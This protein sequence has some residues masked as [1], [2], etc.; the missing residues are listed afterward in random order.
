MRTAQLLKQAIEDNQPKADFRSHIGASA[1]GDE[2]TLKLWLNYRFAA[3]PKF[4]ANTLLKFADGHASE[5]ITAK[6]LNETRGVT[7]VTENNGKQFTFSALGGHFGGSV[8]GI[9]CGV[10]Q[11]PFSKMIWEHKCVDQKE[12]NKIQRAIDK[13]GEDRALEK[14]NYKYYA[15]AQTYM[16]LSGIKNHFLTVATS[17]SRD[18]LDVVTRYNRAVALSLQHRANEIIL[19]DEGYD[20]IR[21]RADKYPCTYCSNSPICHGWQLPEVTCRS[22]I[23]G[24]PAKDSGWGCYL[25]GGQRNASEQMEACEQHLYLPAIV[26]KTLKQVDT[27]ERYVTYEHKLT[28][29]LIK[30]EVID[31][32][33]NSRNLHKQSLPEGE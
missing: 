31:G 4:D 30:N 15:Q 7:L 10:V 6:R 18:Y 5:A 3:A 17:G 21:A 9:I 22:C 16:H 23:N 13:S 19:N 14:W 8:D 33:S 27:G 24:H 11:S 20:R 2:C 29:E 26:N 1:I 25:K 32:Q 12:F 28:G